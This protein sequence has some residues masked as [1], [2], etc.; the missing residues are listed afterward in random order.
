MRGDRTAWISLAAALL[1]SAAPALAQAPDAATRKA[2]RILA[3]EGLAHYDRGEHGAALDKLEKADALVSA[4]TVDLFAA[5]CLVKLGRLAD[6]S[7]RYLEV[8]RATL[9]GD[10]PAA[11]K[12]AQAEARQELEALAPRVPSIRIAIEGSARAVRVLLDGKD[13]PPGQIGDLRPVDPGSHR[14]EAMSGDAKATRD[15]ELKEGES[16]VVVLRLAAPAAPAPRPRPAPD[17]D[18]GGTQR[19]LGWIGLGVGALGMATWGVAGALA[20]AKQGSLVDEGCGEAG[21]PIGVDP[22]AYDPLRLTSTIG[23]WSGLVGLGAGAALL[24]TAPR[25][26]PAPATARV[27]PWATVE[28]ATRPGQPA[29]AAVA[30][31][32]KGVF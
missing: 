13:I 1:A 27:A 4:P 12:D 28:R 8:T 7:A 22:G 2:A 17:P 5:R 32:V 20:F 10:A 16:T 3:E 31:G 25:A 6:A 26:T 29:G 30:A 24:L 9:E 18:T 21:C 15:I 19:T 11:F 23:F 14:V